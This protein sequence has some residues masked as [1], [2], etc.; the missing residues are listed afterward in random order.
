M[1]L[2]KLKKYILF[3]LDGTL[4]DPK[5]GIC[6]CVQY[7]LES[8]GISEPDL[9][10]LEPFIGPPLIDSFMDF[11]DM[12]KEDAQKA[13]D[14]YRERFSVTG[15]FENKV[16][17][18]IM[19]MLKTLKK[20][21]FNLAVASSKP[22]VFV[23]RIL[24]HFHMAK[25]FDVVVGSNLDGT[26]TDKA[27]II[28][29]ALKKLFKGEK[30]NKDLIYMVGDRKFDCIGAQKKGIECVA[31]AY[32]YGDFEELVEA[33]ADYIVFTPK[34]LEEFL[35]RQTYRAAEGRI[36]RPKGEPIV[37]MP[38]KTG[39]LV[40]GCFLA[41]ICIRGLLE[42][43]L[44]IAGALVLPLLSGGIKEFLT[45]SS[46]VNINSFTF[47]GNMGTIISGLS[48][49]VAGLA[50]LVPAKK[51]IKA[52]AKDSYLLHPLPPTIWQ[53]ALGV[54]ATISS[55]L[56]IQ[57]VVILTQLALSSDKYQEVGSQ[58]YSCMF[59]VGLLVYGFI[60]AISEEVLFRGIIFPVFRRYIPIPIAILV[61][62]FLFGVYHGNVIQG[63]YAFIMGCLM[64]F[65]Y[66]YF[67]T[68]LAPMIMHILANL[69]AYVGSYTVL[70]NNVII[71]WPF[72]AIMFVIAILSLIFMYKFRTTSR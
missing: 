69:V 50:L 71:S 10:K 39:L 17:G 48:Y 30:V 51:Y 60:S 8:F 46:V 38:I 43:L 28:D 14:K 53:I 4:T 35:M 23:E 21:G 59:G 34:E 19:H 47:N 24:E 42:I 65:G 26:K 56:A 41:F 25:Y 36:C 67:G 63:G 18:G 49:L 66:E 2:E 70:Q 57:I 13:V 1:E 20:H 54:I 11:Y 6:T 52:T 22:Q 44:N 58:Q 37:P 62:S 64:A 12:S 29:D 31:V 9:D 72:C 55:V 27:E 3:D 40:V 16:Y 61:S 45:Y 15:L 32:G 7:A 5:I 33:H 68:F